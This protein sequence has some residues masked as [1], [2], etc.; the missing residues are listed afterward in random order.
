M[1]SR[2][3]QVQCAGCCTVGFAYPIRG[4]TSAAA[5]TSPHVSNSSETVCAFA[6]R[7]FQVQTEDHTPATTSVATAPRYPASPIPHFAVYGQKTIA[8]PSTP[9]SASRAITP[10]VDVSGF[11]NGIGAAPPLAGTDARTGVEA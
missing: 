1:I 3:E 6:A 10:N 4:N 2:Y 8:T 7:C 5:K 9:A 11:A